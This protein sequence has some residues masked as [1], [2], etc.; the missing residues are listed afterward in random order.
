MACSQAIFD[1]YTIWDIV[2][3]FFT[4]TRD[5]SCQKTIVITH[6]VQDSLLEG[7]CSYCCPPWQGVLCAQLKISTGSSLVYFQQSS[8]AM[9]KRVVYIVQFDGT[10]YINMVQ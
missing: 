9:N 1:V 10:I 8:T 3:I 6:Y 4:S 2:F 7:I 5:Y